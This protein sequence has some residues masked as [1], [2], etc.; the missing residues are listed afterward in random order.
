M[1]EKCFSLT[2]S[3]FVSSIVGRKIIWVIEGITFQDT[4]FSPTLLFPWASQI[5]IDLIVALMEHK[6]WME[7]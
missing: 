5:G 7:R 6:I 1:Y 3:K 4:E 2:N